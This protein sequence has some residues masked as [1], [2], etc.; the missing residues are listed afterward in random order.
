MI[1]YSPAIF[2]SRILRH[3]A[4]ALRFGQFSNFCE[5]LLKNLYSRMVI[6]IRRCIVA[7]G[8]SFW[9]EADAILILVSRRE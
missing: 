5:K 6:D 9:G 4:S 1:S 7:A 8:G 3:I 2:R